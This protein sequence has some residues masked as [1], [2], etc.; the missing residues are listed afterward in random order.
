[1]S[2]HQR[3]ACLRIWWRV[4]VLLLFPMLSLACLISPILDFW[5]RRWRWLRR[6]LCILDRAG[7]STRGSEII[8]VRLLACTSCLAV[9]LR[10]SLVAGLAW[11]WLLGWIRGLA[12]L[13]WAWETDGR[14][15]RGWSESVRRRPHVAE[16]WWGRG[17]WWWWLE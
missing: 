15:R 10:R 12:L 4:I 16:V 9:V 1:M 13:L 5:R 14:R 8:V 2:R 3:T 17:W 6:S 11:T 7:G